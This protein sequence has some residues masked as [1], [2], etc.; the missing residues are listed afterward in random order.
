MHNYKQLDGIVSD[1]TSAAHCSSHESMTSTPPATSLPST[2]ESCSDVPPNDPRVER[3]RAAVIEAAVELLM[4]DGPSAVTHA[5]VASSANVSRTT[6]YKHWPTR[7]D[8][9]RSTIEAIGKT[10]PPV[11]SLTGEVR[12]DLELLFRH[13]IDDL[14]DDQRAPLLAIMMERALHDPTVTAVRDDLISEFEPIFQTI[15]MSAVE[16]GDIRRDI[17]MDLAM[18]SI[19]GSF[20]FIRFMSPREFDAAT[21]GRILDDFVSVNRPR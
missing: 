9:L 19:I 7:A 15:I 17:N 12:A 20:L 10:T 21:A 1:D 11:T 16:T 6:A 13:V 3:T 18:A 5:N 8:L 2:S 4:V 14:E